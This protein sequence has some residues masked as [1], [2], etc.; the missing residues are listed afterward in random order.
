MVTLQLLKTR[1]A[2]EHRR[3][4]Y[5]YSQWVKWHGKH[6]QTPITE[7]QRSKWWVLYTD[8]RIKRLA[9]GHEI[10]ERTP[11][12]VPGTEVSTHG[13][14]FI[15]NFEGY[16]GHVYHDAV[17]I[18]TVG[19]GHTEHVPG[20]G[21]WLPHQKRRGF[22]TQG[23]ALELLRHDLNQN[24]APAVRALHLP[25]TQNQFDALTSFVYNVGVGG[26][27]RGTG[28]G[29]LL[30]Q[31][32]YHAAANALLQWDKASGNVLEGLLRRREAE[33]QMF[34]T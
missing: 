23:E 30:R 29:R 8:A 2:L 3:E 31:H 17:G 11:K 5:R 18:P 19:Y 12:F 9:L 20:N 6:P 24:Y 15:A 28:V 25:L 13:T 10:K 14:N 32:Q 33:R 26:V 1:F 22:L 34:L 21:I 7:G 27:G 16:I 4:K